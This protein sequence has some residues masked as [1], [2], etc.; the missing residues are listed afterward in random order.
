MFLFMR[1]LELELN[2][3]KNKNE[4]RDI[5][6]HEDE[7]NTDRQLKVHVKNFIED[8]FNCIPKNK[9]NKNFSLTIDNKNQTYSYSDFSE[10]YIKRVLLPE[11]I[12]P[13]IKQ[14]IKKE[15]R[16]YTN[17]DLLLEFSNNAD[18]FYIPIELKST[19]K[20]S[21]PGSSIQQIELDEWVIFIKHT[22]KD[23]S[24][25]TGQYINALNESMQFPDR[26]PRPKVDFNQLTKWNHENRKDFPT[27]TNSTELQIN[28]SY[29]SY[30]EKVFLVKQ[31]ED[32]LVQ[33]WIDIINSDTI[34]KNEP[35]F[36][37]TIR[38]FT[39]E[40]IK[41]YD[42]L[43]DSDKTILKEDIEKK[44]KNPNK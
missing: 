6:F 27:P 2:L 41:T 7:A 17:P 21:I 30:K 1:E 38:K 24:I 4:L 34:K 39:L 22:A 9:M 3:D 11:E 14:Q 29:K 20:N 33:R 8:R 32:V 40:I 36:N 43:S 42:K 44:I 15:N 18:L 37:K 28:V 10:I 12:T 31:W 35:W 26:S 23:I 13:D 5:S 19:K 25:A 16:V